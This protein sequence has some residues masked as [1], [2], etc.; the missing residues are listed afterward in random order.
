MLSD[1]SRRVRRYFLWKMLSSFSASPGLARKRSTRRSRPSHGSP[2]A[3]GRCWRPLPR[4]S[5]PSR[6]PGG[7]TSAPRPSATTLRASSPS[8]ASTP[9]CRRWYSRPATAWW[10][11]ADLKVTSDA[12]FDNASPVAKRAPCTE[13]LVGRSVLTTGSPQNHKRVDERVPDED[14]ITRYQLHPSGHPARID[15]RRD[16]VLDK[17]TFIAGLSREAAK[18]VFYRREWTDVAEKVHERGPQD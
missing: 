17:P 3:N 11:S 5:M 10:R 1:A 7:F 9:A 2:I 6:S 12:V 13:I 14:R 8:W 15:Q 18:P 16:V 4:D